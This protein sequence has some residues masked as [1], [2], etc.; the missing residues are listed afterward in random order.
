MFCVIWWLDNSIGI[1]IIVIVTTM[2]LN[3]VMIHDT[4]AENADLGTNFW[5]WT[6]GGKVQR[7]SMWSGDTRLVAMFE[8]FQSI[9][10]WISNTIQQWKERRIPKKIVALYIS[11]SFDFQ[12]FE[13]LRMF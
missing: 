1:V 2:V 13:L 5:T 8:S 9:G 7:A 3:I 11:N 10:P 4:A 12:P 6:W